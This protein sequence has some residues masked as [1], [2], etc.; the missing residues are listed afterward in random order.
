MEYMVG[1]FASI[2][3]L[4]VDHLEDKGNNLK[5]LRCTFRALVGLVTLRTD[6]LIMIP[7]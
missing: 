7:E 3:R 1:R 6:S 5:I 2:C 4:V